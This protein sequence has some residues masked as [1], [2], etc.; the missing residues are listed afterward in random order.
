MEPLITVLMPTYK[1]AEN[2]RSAI[3]SILG[4]TFKDFELLIINDNSPDNIDDIISSYGDKRIR[5]IKNEKNLGISR[6]SNLGISLAKG[7]YIARQDH[8][9]ISHPTR[10]E[11]QFDFMENHPDVGVCGCGYKIFG[12]KHKVVLHP[13]YDEDIKAALLFKCPLAHQTAMLRKEM[14]TQFKLKYDESYQTSNDRKLWIDASLYTNFYNIPLSLLDYRMHKNMTSKVKRDIVLQEGRKMREI[15]FNRLNLHLDSR[16]LDIANL[17]LFQGR[18]HIKTMQVLK[19]I[20][21]LLIKFME[22]NQKTKCF[23]EEAFANIC[24]EYFHKRCVN[25]CFFAGRCAS[26]IYKNSIL[27]QYNKNIPVK[28]K[29]IFTVLNTV[30]AFRK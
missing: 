3:D 30:F 27:S 25:Y 4:Q 17:F 7:K 21:Q 28:N 19:E 20:E 24:G 16:E 13:Q 6:C 29:I 8:D 1:G 12:K 10:L 23:E 9:D 15:I 22:A 18:A 2:I 26:D 5:Y 11:E 14:L